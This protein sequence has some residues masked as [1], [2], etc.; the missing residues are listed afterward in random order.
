[1]DG[2]SKQRIQASL[3]R[4]AGQGVDWRNPTHVSAY[5]LARQQTDRP[6]PEQIL[7]IA[8]QSQVT[9]QDGTRLT[10][11]FYLVPRNNFPDKCPPWLQEFLV[12]EQELRDTHKVPDDT[13]LAA[14][15]IV[16][17]SCEL[18]RLGKRVTRLSFEQSFSHRLATP[19]DRAAAPPPASPN[20]PV[21]ADSSVKT[22]L[23]LVAGRGVSAGAPGEQGSAGRADG[24]GSAD[25]PA[26]EALPPVKPEPN[27]C[28]PPTKKQRILKLLQS[29]EKEPVEE[30]EAGHL[31]EL[32]NRIK[33]AAKAKL[34]YCEDATNS[35]TVHF[36]R[37]Q[38]ISALKAEK[39]PH[40]ADKVTPSMVK[41][42]LPQL[43]LKVIY[44]N[45]SYSC[46]THFVKVF[47]DLKQLGSPEP[48]DLAS[49][50][51]FAEAD[52]LGG[53]VPEVAG[54][55]GAKMD[56]FGSQL[57]KHFL[58]L[59]VGALAKA[60]RECTV[61]QKRNSLLQ[62]FYSAAQS[63]D[64]PGK[65]DAFLQSAGWARSMMDTSV[66]PGARVAFAFE[67]DAAKRVAYAASFARLL[68]PEKKE[69][70]SAAP[71]SGQ[72]ASAPGA[73][74]KKED[75]SAPP[76]PG[77]KASALVYADV[78]WSALLCFVDAIDVPKDTDWP[79]FQEAMT[80]VLDA[81][82]RKNQ[83]P[84]PLVASLLDFW[85]EVQTNF[86]HEVWAKDLLAVAA[87]AR[88]KA[89]HWAEVAFGPEKLGLDAELGGGAVLPTLVKLL[90]KLFKFT[91][92][93]FLCALRD[94]LFQFKK[95][96]APAQMPGMTAAPPDGTDA[97]GDGTDASGEAL[98]NAEK[99][100]ESSSD[101]EDHTEE[102]SKPP[103]EKGE[104]AASRF[105]VGDVI[106]LSRNVGVR[107]KNCQAIVTK[108]TARQVK[109]DVISG[110]F[111][112]KGKT[113]HMK[114]C[115]LV[116][117]SKMR[118]D[119]HQGRHP[120]PAADSASAAAA[121]PASSAASASSA[122]AASSKIEDEKLCDELFNL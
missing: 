47:E 119:L 79:A 95:A 38:A 71:A 17:G 92:P 103:P 48:V 89:E 21:D 30:R 22:G 43:I 117:P 84:N 65:R 15:F 112:H 36:W 108:V 90:D 70:A 2:L 4:M 53:A 69:D 11:D 80:Q 75:A 16:D 106:Q 93:E 104:E 88:L 1:M 49:L 3:R 73:P 31:E 5:L 39:S 60:A 110:V 76:V 54:D 115:T 83:V 111:Q 97:R 18:K 62:T 50:K 101:Q 61:A 44:T 86:G 7:A 116:R 66:P 81:G 114:E 52:L 6:K 100:A 42:H 82:V 57:Y 12:T 72:T 27:N 118:E 20:V 68:T 19:L 120:K 74:D 33:K 34:L 64:D 55:L 51:Q 23:A 102:R 32:M 35:A 109:V 40:D 122:S 13:D 9:M 63:L 26:G 8:Q 10:R 24:D 37:L 91:R 58:E 78:N 56:F 87:R 29:E 85:L 46:L 96:A 25:P 28:G 121:A 113:F 94:K 14:V 77:Q 107:Y 99:A 105:F 59:R 98:K 41:Q 67:A 45:Q